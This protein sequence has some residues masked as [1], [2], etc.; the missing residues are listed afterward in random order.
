[1]CVRVTMDRQMTRLGTAPER[2]TTLAVVVKEV[3]SSGTAPTGN[4][5]SVN[6]PC[7]CSDEVLPSLHH[8]P[9]APQW[10]DYAIYEGALM[11]CR[12]GLLMYRLTSTF[13]A[14]YLHIC[15]LC[16]DLAPGT[17]GAK[18]LFQL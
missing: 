8:T 5:P 12:L 15:T 14:V 2:L 17:M 9:D 6:N 16:R 3:P 10:M 13:S 18:V 1:M 7:S 11:A 4:N